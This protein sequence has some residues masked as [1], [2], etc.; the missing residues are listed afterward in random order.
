V[1]EE[2]HL[3]HE[4]NRVIY[5]EDFDDDLMHEHIMAPMPNM[6]KFKKEQ[7]AGKLKKN[8]NVPAAMASL[9]GEAVMT[10]EQEFHQFRKYNYL[11]YR[12]LKL[13]KKDVSA[14]AQLEILRFLNEALEVKHFLVRSNMRLALDAA[15]KFAHGTGQVPRLWELFS[16]CS[17]SLIRCVNYFDFTFG[18]KFGTYTT[19]AL[20]ANLGRETNE[21]RSHQKR[22][23]SGVGY[24]TF[25]KPIEN[26][27]VGDND[28]QRFL[29]TV[30][31]D[32]LSH[33]SERSRVVICRYLLS[34]DSPTLDE[35]GDEFGIT[36]ERIRQIKV[37]SI[38]KMRAVVERGGVSLNGFLQEFVKPQEEESDA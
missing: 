25:E 35:L 1:L 4:L 15:K 20:K 32:L 7:A 11:K 29:K 34:V 28:R 24:E 10:R 9:Y 30:V 13:L 17:L 16:E 38:K 21:F 14:I 37:N 26:D 8:L 12:A 2:K 22:Y 5:H 27:V 6:D 18:N 3:L 33:L 23:V 31:N 19:W 36:K